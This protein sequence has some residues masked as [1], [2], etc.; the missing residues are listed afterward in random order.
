MLNLLVSQTYTSADQDII[1]VSKPI[2]K[3][4]SL[5]YKILESSL[6]SSTVRW[7]SELE[8]LLTDEL[9]KTAWTRTCHFHLKCFLYHC[10]STLCSAYTGNWCSVPP[11]PHQRWE[12]GGKRCARYSTWPQTAHML[13]IEVTLHFTRCYHNLHFPSLQT[14]W[15]NF[16][17]QCT[18]IKN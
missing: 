13:G 4:W 14:H 7:I 9:V 6:T 12:G 8:Q 18:A 3:K 11:K 10:E 16:N 1:M 2:W 15:S 5:M 17:F